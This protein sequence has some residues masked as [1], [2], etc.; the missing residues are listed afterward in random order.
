VEEVVVVVEVVVEVAQPSE[1]VVVE[2]VAAAG[3]PEL[4][5]VGIF[6]G[7]SIRLVLHT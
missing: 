7:T 1:Q 3:L 6:L 4:V 2:V 5:E